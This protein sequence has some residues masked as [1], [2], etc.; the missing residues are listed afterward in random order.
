MDP[1]D[2]VTELPVPAAVDSCGLR[3]EQSR[4]LFWKGYHFSST[5]Q[6]DL[7]KSFEACCHFLLKDFGNLMH[8]IKARC[9]L[10]L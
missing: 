10:K 2:C 3:C 7:T 4:P 6:K 8:C 9:K 5:V 1:L